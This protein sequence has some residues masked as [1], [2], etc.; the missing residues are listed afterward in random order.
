MGLHKWLSIKWSF[1]ECSNNPWACMSLISLYLSLILLE[2]RDNWDHAKW[3]KPVSSIPL[4]SLLQFLHWVL[5]L[6]SLNDVLLPRCISWTKTFPYK[7]LFLRLFYYSNNK[8]QSMT[9]FTFFT[10]W[11]WKASGFAKL[12]NSNIFHLFV[13]DGKEMN[14]KVSVLRWRTCTITKILKLHWYKV[15]CFTYTG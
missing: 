15:R 4:M 14:I 7:F 11:S 2:N 1:S 9:L 10:L 8:I 5:V 12:I 13:T 6:A 3:I